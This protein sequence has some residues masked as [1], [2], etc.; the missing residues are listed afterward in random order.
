MWALLTHSLI[1]L[2]P[3]ANLREDVKFHSLVS[4]HLMP[5]C[6]AIH[7][8]TGRVTSWPHLS[9]WQNTHELQWSEKFTQKRQNSALGFIP[10]IHLFQSAIDCNIKLSNVRETS[11]QYQTALQM[12]P[13]LSSHFMLR[14]NLF[15]SQKGK[16]FLQECKATNASQNPWQPLEELL[17]NDTS[18]PFLQETKSSIFSPHL[19]SLHLSPLPK[20]LISPH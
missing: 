3:V 9:Q 4:H 10:T 8:C 14:L 2:L 11:M 18:F 12:Q 13:K 19:K 20:V 15:W 1:L 5:V 17:H 7:W 16:Q 6:L